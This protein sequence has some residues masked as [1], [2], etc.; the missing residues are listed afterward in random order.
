MF[1]DTYTNVAVDTW[2]TSWSSNFRRYLVATKQKNIVLGI[3]GIEAT[4]TPINASAMTSSTLIFGL[5]IL[6]NLKLS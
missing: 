2:R 5:L 6:Q 4:T 3:V 1:S